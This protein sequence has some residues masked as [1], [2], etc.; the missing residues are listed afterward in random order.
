MPFSSLTPTLRLLAPAQVSTGQVFAVTLE[1]ET[2]APMEPEWLGLTVLV[3][4][5]YWPPSLSQS[6][7]AE[8]FE[9]LR[10]R[11]ERPLIPAGMSRHDAWFEIPGT[12]PPSYESTWAYVRYRITA[13]LSIP[14]WPD[15]TASWPLHVTQKSVEVAPRS[16][17]V[18]R[19]GMEVALE[20]D[21]VAVSG[22]LGGRVAVL[23]DHPAPVPVDF[24]LR[25]VID[26][27]HSRTYDRVIPRARCSVVVPGGSRE[28]VAFRIAIDRTFTP[29]FQGR[30]FSRHWELACTT[31]GP[32]PLE[33]LTRHE[34]ILQIE[35]VE[36]APLA[37][38]SQSLVAPMVG[39]AR[40]DG[41]I[42]EVA[43]T[44]GWTAEGTRLSRSFRTPQGDVHA[45]VDW[46]TRGAQADFDA[47]ATLPSLGLG[48][49]VLRAGPLGIVGGDIELGEWSFDVENSVQ[50]RDPAQAKAL[51][52]PMVARFAYLLTRL[53][54]HTVA[55][56]LRG[57]SSTA[58]AFGAFV[59]AVEQALGTLS[60]AVDRLPAP[61][62]THVDD[63]EA[64]R[65]ASLLRGTYHPGDLAIRGTIED[66]TV[67][68]VPLFESSRVIALRVVVS[69]VANAA[70]RFDA[71][72]A[73][74][75][76]ALSAPARHLLAS[77]PPDVSLSIADGVGTA[78][79]A[80]PAMR[81]TPIEHARG[82]SLAGLLVQL[83]RA[84]GT[85][86]GV[87][88]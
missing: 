43:R 10:A 49:Q 56:E 67:E 53:D 7:L 61:V 64:R 37:A 36:S 74:D 31:A 11:L 62:G 44:T 6:L 39:D 65:I 68:I 12:H 76:T 84:L 33:F 73:G 79:I 70:L 46:T 38:L 2:N 60:A 15:A 25:E 71:R 22:V 47:V 85:E 77:L 9:P 66:R 58:E 8:P 63:A 35:I 78:W 34:S 82:W 57:T 13:R 41:I 72:Q 16:A 19:N 27:H 21:R 24:V 30:S 50:A 42:R 69:P 18:A 83:S 52:T 3:E 75:L 23:A 54:D 20:S 48:L 14:W 4:D 29:T 55:M 87:F 5:G 59:H 88:R 17:V 81:P 86:R 45:R 1:I 80:V 32:G 40:V 28:G 51:L 26:P